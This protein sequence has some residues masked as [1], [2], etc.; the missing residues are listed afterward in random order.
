VARKVKRQEGEEKGPTSQAPV[1]EEL[2]AIKALLMVLALKIGATTNEIGA[3]L[4]VTGRRVRQ[5]V[6]AS[7]IK[8][9]KIGQGETEEH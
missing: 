4:G 6:P 3:S 2:R 1:L 9:L 7:E 5:M 8:K